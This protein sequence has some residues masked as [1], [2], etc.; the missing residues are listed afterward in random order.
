LSGKN[1]RNSPYKLR[2]QGLVVGHDDRRA[3]QFLITC[4][5]VK[6]LPEPVTPSSVCAA[7]PA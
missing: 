6:V 2:R 7:R 5:M 3:L 4:A 1:S